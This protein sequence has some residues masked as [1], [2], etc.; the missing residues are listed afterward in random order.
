MFCIVIVHCDHCSL[1]SVTL[2]YIQLLLFI[3]IRIIVH[4]QLYI[5]YE[6]V[7]P[8]LT[9]LCCPRISLQSEVWSSYSPARDK[10]TLTHT[11]SNNTHSFTLNHTHALALGAGL[12]YTTLP[13]EELVYILP[14]TS[15]LGRLPVVQAGDTGTIPFS[16]RHGCRNGAPRYDHSLA[17]ADTSA[18]AWDGCPCTS[19]ILERWAGPATREVK[20]SSVRDLYCIVLL[21]VYYILLPDLLIL[22][23]HIC[24]YTVNTYYYALLH[25][26]F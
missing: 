7:F 1:L 9:M 22:I 10:H 20:W 6:S 5:A 19:W 24:Y 14:I 18:G 11:V 15:I 17:T 8:L 4:C 3:Y 13:E 21:S 2:L 23:I 12:I 25:H 26:S 16:Y